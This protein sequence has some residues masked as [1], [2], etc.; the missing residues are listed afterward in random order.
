[1]DPDDS[2]NCRI[3]YLQVIIIIYGIIIII[4][5]IIVIIYIID[6]AVRWNI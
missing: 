4:V 3:D 6:L 2:G 1:M 5:V